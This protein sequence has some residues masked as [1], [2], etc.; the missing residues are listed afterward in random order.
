MINRTYKLQERTIENDLSM[1]I[2]LDL[3]R[4]QA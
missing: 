1:S 3:T 2:Y 4:L